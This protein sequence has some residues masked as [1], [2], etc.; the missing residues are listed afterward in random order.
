MRQLLPERGPELDEPALAAV[1]AYPDTDR[2][3]L[4]ANM[5]ASADGAAWVK[6]LSEGLSGRGDRRLFSLLRGLADVILVGAATARAEGYGPA[7]PRPAWRELRAGR[8]LSPPIAVVT[9]RLDLDLSDA[10]FTDAPA[11]ARTIV[12][13]T[14]S[15]PHD[16]RAAA[17]ERAD[18]VIA[19]AER[20]DPATAL[21]A[22]AERGHRRVLCEG[23]PRL[24]A[25]VAAA[26][27]L[28]ELCLSVSPLLVS[29]DAARILAGPPLPEPRRLRLAHV[30]EDEGFLFLR[31]VRTQP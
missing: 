29:G 4:R 30:L 6:G 15:A 10:L 17:A 19:G 3:W 27:A 20:V 8:P 28:D 11:S 13:T 7:R 5:V 24:L 2:L 18:V 9:R 26:G 12:I 1:Y 14:E 22:L 16:R 31:Y 23:G 25:Q 21:A